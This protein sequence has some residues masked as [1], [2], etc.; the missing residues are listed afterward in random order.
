[1]DADH[2]EE[3]ARR[4]YVYGYEYWNES[5]DY[6]ANKEKVARAMAVEVSL[7]MRQPVCLEE[8]KDLTNLFRIE[9]MMTEGVEDS[10]FRLSNDQIIARGPVL[11]LEILISVLA[12]ISEA[13]WHVNSVRDDQRYHEL[14]DLMDPAILAAH[15]EY[16]SMVARILEMADKAGHPVIPLQITKRSAP[17][18]F[19]PLFPQ[20]VSC[21]LRHY[22]FEGSIV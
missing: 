20:P 10:R 18:D 22:L 3:R 6:M 11:S 9:C 19:P 17:T 12:P 5:P 21:Q 2:L 13:T 8:P 7:I 14:F 4:A 16:E 1:M 15:S